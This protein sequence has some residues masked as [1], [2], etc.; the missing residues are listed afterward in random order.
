M[1]ADPTNLDPHSTVDG[2]SVLTMGRCYDRLIELEPGIPTPGEPLQFRPDLA[3]SWEISEDGMTYTFTLR[4]G[5][6]FADGTPLDAEAVKWSFD[7]LQ[8]INKAGA[9]WP[10]QRPSMRARCA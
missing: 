9:N 2:L 8:T 7:R 1:G 5:L 3:E 4:E 6:Q 10:R